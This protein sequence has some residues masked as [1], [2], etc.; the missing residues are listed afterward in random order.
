[1]VL[2]HYTVS[3]PPECPSA[4]PLNPNPGAP[5]ADLTALEGYSGLSLHQRLFLYAAC[6][7][8]MN[9]LPTSSAGC[10]KSYVLEFLRRI[11]QRKRRSIAFTSTTGVSATQLPN[12]M[13]LHSFLGLGLAE[14]DPRDL[15]RRGARRKEIKQKIL[16]TD[17]LVIDEVSMMPARLLDVV[18]LLAQAVHQNFDAPFGGKL[19]VI[20]VGI[21]PS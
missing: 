19:Q 1:M 9:L 11:C 3:S 12:G 16:S 20:L 2:L 6:Y 4:S 17:V 18:N 15:A 14:G 7:G 21:S 10:G 5:P 13:T 8:R